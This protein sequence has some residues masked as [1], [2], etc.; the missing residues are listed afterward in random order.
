[1]KISYNWIKDY[2]KIDIDPHKLSEILTG[3]G[4][5]VEG[6]EEWES[7]KGG[8]KGVIVG[9]VL[10]CKKHPD[11][12]KLSVTTVNIGSPEPLHIVC[13]APNVAAGQKVPVAVAGTIL[14][15]GGEPFELKRTKI[16]GEISEG[17]ICAEDEL[18]IGTDH[19][20]IIVLDN[21]AKPGTPASE[22]FGIKHDTIFEIGLTPN[23]I[24]SGSHFGV[25]RDL[26]AYLNL[27]TGNGYRAVGPSVDRFI[28]DSNNAGFEVIIE[29]KTDCP[30][31][32]AIT[33]SD[34]KIA[35]SP[36]WLKTK[37]R[38]IGLNP[39]S[40]VVDITNFVQ[41]EIGQPL[42]AFD[43]DRITGKKVIIRN[44]PGKTKF[45]T[46][47]GIERSLSSRDLMIC[48]EEEGM[49]IAGVFGGIKSGV[50]SSTKNIFLESAHFNPVAIRKTS[51]RHGLQTD[52]SFRFERGTDP[53][54]TIWALKR[55]ALL[56]RE[57]A[58]G[59]I[60]SDVI[61]VYPQKIENAR[62][63]VTYRNIERLIGKK[64]EKET[65]RRIL[66]LLDILILKEEND[67]LFLEIP[68]YRVDVKIEAD[69]IEEILRIYGYNN[70]EISSH[71]NSTLTYLDK[72][73][74]EKVIN[75]ISELLS[76]NGFAEIMCN[77]LNPAAWYNE[78]NDFDSRQTVILANPLSSDLNAMRQS[79]IF[80]GLNSVIWNINR[81]CFDLKF[82]E[83]G[84]CYYRSKPPNPVP[85]ADDF[86]ERTS[87]DL[88]ITGKTGK[89]NWNHKTNPT[90]FFRIKSATEMVLTR[91]GINIS[92][93]KN[94]ESTKGYFAESIT[95]INNNRLVAE[96]GR[97]SKTYLARFDIGQDVFYSH[98]E[99]N[100]IMKMIR[101][102]VISYNELPKYPSV[103]RDLAILLDKGTRFGQ[104]REIAF[105]T[106]KSI[107]REVGLFDVY[108]S[109]S[110][111]PNKKS[112]AISFLLRD[113]L[114]TLTDKNIDKVM[115]NLIRAFENELGAKIR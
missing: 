22:Y 43:A 67:T 19:E 11:A 78:N 60:T 40:N 16:R 33:I 4:L 65:V 62:T 81:Q 69:V 1:M 35:E 80:G 85:M 31:Y 94:S 5:E 32:S 82:Y 92:S 93:L 101:H 102:N 53:N 115:N 106:E 77:S 88:F 110:L 13:G 3:I 55:A 70:V 38:S 54:I 64:I 108:E 44:L 100:H 112:Y 72:P 75:I 104:I 39:I 42:H 29:N 111:G 7:V 49:C 24:D 66:G 83:F 51:K 26:A 8:M 17:M 91:L 114:R 71:V 23:R 105:K 73:D 56:M 21:N 2:L 28:A 6:V 90:D 46:L 109:D 18:G 41:H 63:E 9:E 50:T 84:N 12:D 79:L 103:R 27:N 10:T 45:I 76:A 96:A 99:W 58:G 97:V 98:I 36:E 86:E 87:L 107:L 48:N 25:A 34:V 52:A 57:I 89:E 47:D 74:R 59:K 15:R 61:D 20:G 68:A 37:L 30:R 113:D 14:F 95:Y